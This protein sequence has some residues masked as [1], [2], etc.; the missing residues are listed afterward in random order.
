MRRSAAVSAEAFSAGWGA[1][2]KNLSLSSNSAR[3]DS[4]TASVSSSCLARAASFSMEAALSFMADSAALFLSR[5]EDFSSTAASASFFT[6]S[7]LC[8][9]PCAACCSELLSFCISSARAR[10]SAAAASRRASRSAVCAFQDAISERASSTMRQIFSTSASRPLTAD[11]A[12][13]M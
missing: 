7:N 1:V 2:S 6:R 4:R 12:L 8:R 10:F 3:R 9:K 5:T 11:L 13:W